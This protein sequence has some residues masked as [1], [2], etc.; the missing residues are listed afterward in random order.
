MIAAPIPKN[1]QSRLMA[2]AGYQILRTKIERQFEE[3]TEMAARVCQTKISAVSL[4]GRNFQWFKSIQGLDVKETGRDISFCGHAIN[5]PNETMIV[6]DATK[7]LRFYDNPLV[8][9]DPNIRFYAG[10]PLVDDEGHALGTLCVIDPKSKN[11]TDNQ[12]NALKSLA[13]Q[14]MRLISSRAWQMS[15]DYDNTGFSYYD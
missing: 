7:D 6:E 11:I 12:I 4:V 13:E 8:T 15:Y 3:I 2:L 5:N 10:V 9:Q 1:D 14:T